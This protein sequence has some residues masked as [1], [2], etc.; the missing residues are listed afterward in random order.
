MQRVD[1]E[2]FF[3]MYVPIEERLFVVLVQNNVICFLALYTQHRNV[4]NIGIESS[5][6]EFAYMRYVAFYS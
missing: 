4:T 1:I 6:W 2:V 3:T 5:G